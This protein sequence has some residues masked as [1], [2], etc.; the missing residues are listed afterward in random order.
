[1][2]RL[3]ANDIAY[4]WLAHGRKC[5]AAAPLGE[6]AAVR[7]DHRLGGRAG[8]RE[9]EWCYVGPKYHLVGPRH[10][11][12]DEEPLVHLLS[13]IIRR[14]VWKAVCRAANGW[15]FPLPHLGADGLAGLDDL[16]ALGDG[17]VD[18]VLAVEPGPR[19]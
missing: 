17:A 19:Q 7:D 11:H 12:L 18:D 8:L 15:C 9:R 1:M 16:H 6:L 5:R 14:F 3:T 4:V 2:P 13:N 10:F